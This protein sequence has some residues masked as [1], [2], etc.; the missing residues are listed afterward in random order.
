MENNCKLSVIVPVYNGA[1]F[2][3]DTVESILN[4]TYKELEL[5][6]VDDGSK[7]ESLDICNRYAKSDARVKVIHQSNAG[8]SEARYTGY[9]NAAEGTDIAFLD[10]DDIFKPTMF[11]DM[12]KQL[13][14]NKD[15]DIVYVCAFNAVEKQINEW[16]WDYEEKEDIS[17]I[18]GIEAMDKQFNKETLKG[19]IGYLWGLVMRREF[20][21]KMEPLF[22]KVRERIPQ[23]FLNDVYCTPRF[24]YNSSKVAFI[25]QIYI[26]RRISPFSDSRTIK[27]NA[28]HYELADANRMNLEFYKEIKDDFAYK[29]QL[30]GFYLVILKLW[31]Q[32]EM[33][34]DNAEKKSKCQN[35]VEELY[36]LYYKELKSLRSRNVKEFLMKCTALIWGKSKWLWIQSVGRLRYNYGYKK[37]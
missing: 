27:P 23:N 28:L 26:L 22:L 16:K 18:S 25:N 11:E 24:L 12:M 32:A 4:Q 19:D 37:R 34:E 35:E 10:A 1:M 2:L 6:L 31:Y 17:L 7:D 15:V 33:A 8:M 29:G 13:E 14:K 30:I 21:D 36:W 3:A 5:I 9:K 20:M